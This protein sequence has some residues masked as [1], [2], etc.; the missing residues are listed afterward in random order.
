[1]KNLLLSVVLLLTVSFAFASNVNPVENVKLEVKTM[2]ETETTVM[3]INFNSFEDFN[4][5]NTSQL[6]ISDDECTASVS[7]T[8][9]VGVGSTYASATVSASGIPCDEIGATIK[10]LKAQALAALK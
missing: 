4:S 6:D 10:R 9:S 5:F 2:S 7:V 3:N 1:M 8:V